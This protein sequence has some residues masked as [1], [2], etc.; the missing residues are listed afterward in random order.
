MQAIEWR[1]FLA[2]VKERGV[3][4]PLEITPSGTILDGRH[5]LRAAREL[6]LTA[7]PVRVVEPEDEVSHMLR[8]A[9][10]RRQLTAS[11]KA[12]LA[13]ELEEYE[14]LRERARE[15]Q[16]S[17]LRQ[18]TEV[19]TLPPRC[20]RSCEIVARTAG[21]SPRTVQDA[22]TVRVNDPQLFE[23]IKQGKTPAHVAARRVR[24]ARRDLVLTTPPLPN[25]P[26]ELIYADPPWQL[27]NPDSPDAPDNHYPTMSLEEI[28][29]LE[30]PSA[31]SALLFLWA[32]NSKLP[33][34]LEV[35]AAWGFEFKDSFV[36]VKDW[37]GRGVWARHRHELLLVGRKGSFSPPDPEDRSDSVIEAPR[38]AHSAK[39]ALTYELI[40]RAYPLASKLELFARGVTR[41]D[42]TFWGNEVEAA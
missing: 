27:G 12:A 28:K 33:E 7:V 23:E 30:I 40:E 5:R 22:E 16:L 11:Q 21:V 13:L 1:A 37:I 24:R 39:P 9:L 2:D 20:E 3:V 31:E 19:A 36:W 29:A 4:T 17:N 10:S 32:V 8:A 34:A 15:L 18:N 42:W 38:G 26:F 35:M 6:E 25:G 14:Q 41:S